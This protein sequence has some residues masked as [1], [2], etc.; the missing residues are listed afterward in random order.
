MSGIALRANL[1]RGHLSPETIKSAHANFIYVYVRLTVRYSNDFFF[2]FFN[3]YLFLIRS[4]V[5][6]II[7]CKVLF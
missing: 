4:Q 7:G 2:S 6:D 1:N 3:S 5:S